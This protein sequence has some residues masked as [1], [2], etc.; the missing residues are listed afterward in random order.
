VVR[1]VKEKY[2]LSFGE[3]AISVKG[4]NKFLQAVDLI[5][6]WDAINSIFKKCSSTSPYGASAYS[7]I[8]LFK[9]ILLQTWYNLSDPV[10]EEQINDRISFIRFL[11]ISLDSPTPD[12]S[13][14]SRF[15]TFL[16]KENLFNELFQEVNKQLI[17]HNLIVKNGAIVDATVISSARRPRKV[18]QGEV[19]EDRKEDVV[20]SQD[21]KKAAREVEKDT[22]VVTFSNDT[23][24]KWLKKRGKFIYGYKAHNL[25][26]YHGYF[27]GGHVTPANVS[28]INQLEAMILESNLES[29]IFVLGDKGYMS[30]KNV[31]LLKTLGFQDGLMR[32]NVKN[33]KITEDEEFKNK[34]IS[35]IR[36]R[37]EQS[38]GLLKKHFGYEKMRYIGTEKCNLENTLKM[39]SFNIKKGVHSLARDLGNRNKKIICLN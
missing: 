14:I 11:K 34:E 13:T 9:I 30:K 18:I 6:D 7:K 39:L 27:L 12:H 21:S 17:H 26:D 32:K 29:G 37:V 15:R 23:D 8:L 10:V 31:E 28:D 5:L 19:A 24:A 2:N 38:F 36:Y 1:K 3:M 33:K 25:V 22:P 35:K 4:N 16:I 20:G